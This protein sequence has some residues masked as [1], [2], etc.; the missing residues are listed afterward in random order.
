MRHL[1]HAA[2]PLPSAGCNIRKEGTV[3]TLHAFVLSFIRIRAFEAEAQR[4]K[5]GQANYGQQP[6]A[7]SFACAREGWFLQTD[8]REPHRASPSHP[9]LSYDD[10]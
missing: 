1:A 7:L 2:S 6:V 5:Q 3:A 4:R 10:V 8:E 9:H